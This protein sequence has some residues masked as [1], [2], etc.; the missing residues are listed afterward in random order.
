MRIV[1][2][3]AISQLS[4]YTS[5]ASAETPLAA[6]RHPLS[7]MSSFSNGTLTARA[8]EAL[9]KHNTTQ[10]SEGQRLRNSWED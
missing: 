8:I 7:V 4:A 1:V 10:E 2:R 9:K 6:F 3:T 5:Q